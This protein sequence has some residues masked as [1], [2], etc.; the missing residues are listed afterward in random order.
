MTEGSKLHH[1]AFSQCF[2]CCLIAV[3]CNEEKAISKQTIY[4]VGLDI[5]GKEFHY[6]SF[7]SGATLLDADIVLF[8]PNLDYEVDLINSSYQGKPNLSD[9]SSTQNRESLAHWRNELKQA[10]ENG[11]TIFV[12]L[13]KPVKVYA[14]TGS[15][16]FSGTGRSMKTIR[17][18]APLD[19]YEA[20]PVQF[21]LFTPA[22]GEKVRFTSRGSLLSSYWKA[23]EPISHYEAYYELGKST[24]LMTT[25]KGEKTV[26]SLLK[27]KRGRMI[28]LP[29]LDFSADE[30][31]YFDEEKEQD[32]WSDEAVRFAKALLGS[33]IEIHR[34]LHSQQDRTPTPD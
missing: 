29:V 24:P 18:V 2:L 34:T 31:I 20:L 9:H 19:S 21:D 16:E 4:C 15:Q 8:E 27:G 25:Y 11:A 13:K 6:I 12:F 5:P 32:F 26:A 14:A 30:F 3:Q 7:H 23:M 17:H 22:R 1:S 10:Y 28:L 33:L